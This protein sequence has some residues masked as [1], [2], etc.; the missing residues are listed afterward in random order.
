MAAARNNM[1]VGIFIPSLD[2]PLTG[3][4]RSVV[5]LTRALAALNDGP[6]VVLL[7]PGSLGPL[8]GEGLRCGLLPGRLPSRL[9]TLGNAVLSS[10]VG[11]RLTL[12]T[13]GSALVPLAA[14]RLGLDV[15]HDLANIPPHA[16]G[17][18][19]VRTVV[20]IHDLISWSHPGSNDWMDDL[21]QHHWLP[22]VVP[23]ADA[24]ITVSN[25]SKADVVHYLRVQA[26]KVRTVY[27]GVS[28][29]YRPLPADEVAKL[30]ARYGLPKGYILLVGSA[31]ERKNLRLLLE[32]CIRLWQEGEQR[33]LVIVGPRSPKPKHAAIMGTVERL[34]LD[35]RVLFTGYVVETDL[36][37]LY[38]G[39]D[40]FVY[41]SHYEGFGLPPLEAMACG[42]AVVCSNASS[43]P[44]VV[45]DAALTVDL[46]DVDALVQAMHR[47]LTDVSLREELR[48]KGLRRAGH[49]TW[50]R[51]ARETLDVYRQVCA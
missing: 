26:N 30:R 42:T 13:L 23:H 37:G 38:N 44:E 20:T 47:L 34:N 36:P 29:R 16:F 41:P 28:A 48:Q 39:A 2:G 22:R 45:G 46:S 8:A 12:L 51:A 40:L 43:L 5:E 15:V 17:T 3:V 24:V 1:R 35:H 4:G 50:E 11:T 19:G 6:E 7:T 9:L 31:D 21:I 33:S 25:V 32:A 49:F 27:L 18:G 10:L 14:R